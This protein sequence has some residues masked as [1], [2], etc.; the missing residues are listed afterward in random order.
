MTKYYEKMNGNP[1]V[2]EDP[3]SIMMWLVDTEKRKSPNLLGAQKAEMNWNLSLN[4]EIDMI[5][6]HM[7]TMAGRSR[8]SIRKSMRCPAKENL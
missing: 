3:L 2:K 8:Y 5:L 7:G 4:P 6:Q 1:R